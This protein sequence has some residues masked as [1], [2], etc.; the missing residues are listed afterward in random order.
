MIPCSGREEGQKCG[1]GGERWDEELKTGV[2]LNYGECAEGLTCE[3]DTRI[4][5]V[6]GVC[7]REG[8]WFLK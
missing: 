3:H 7:K 2:P 1:V 8:S 4:A 6:P 5:D